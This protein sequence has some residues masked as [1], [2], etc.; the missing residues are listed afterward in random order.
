MTTLAR[1]EGFEGVEGL[2]AVDADARLCPDRPSLFNLVVG[3]VEGGGSDISF[4]A[5]EM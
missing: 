1:A 2:V 4:S 5:H 3:G